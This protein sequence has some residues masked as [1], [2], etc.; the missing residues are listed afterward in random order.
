MQ[1]IIR[2]LL[3]LTTIYYSPLSIHIYNL[4]SK[5][6]GTFFPQGPDLYLNYPEM[7]LHTYK[8]IEYDSIGNSQ[9]FTHTLLS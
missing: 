8:R 9:R 2:F 6:I 3:V 7:L 1:A 4:H 5:Y